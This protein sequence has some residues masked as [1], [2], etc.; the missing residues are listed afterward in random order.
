[1]VATLSTYLVKKANIA[2]NI[3]FNSLNSPVV[4]IKPG[5]ITLDVSI[6]PLACNRRASSKDV[7]TLQSLLSL[8][9]LSASYYHEDK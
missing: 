4:G 2:T 8:Y 6:L 9:A 7:M 1:M 3:G 5:F